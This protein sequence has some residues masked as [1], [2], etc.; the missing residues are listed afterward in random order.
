[1]QLRPLLNGG[2]DGIFFNCE[3]GR[4]QVGEPLEE[5]VWR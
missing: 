5:F 2:A 3:P 4:I 1:M